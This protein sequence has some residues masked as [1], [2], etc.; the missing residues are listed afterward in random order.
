[1][2]L[3]VVLCLFERWHTLNFQKKKT[4]WRQIF[5][6]HR[7][8]E[9]WMITYYYPIDSF[10]Q[11][12]AKIKTN[13]DCERNIRTTKRRSLDSFSI[14][15]F[16]LSLLQYIW[17]KRIHKFGGN[18]KWPK[19]YCVYRS[20]VESFTIICIRYT[21]HLLGDILFLFFI[22]CTYNNGGKRE[23]S[24]CITQLILLNNIPSRIAVVGCSDIQLHS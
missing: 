21:I 5:W 18:E 2:N 4:V 22:L 7:K 1:M 16:W 19:Y 23:R 12:K 10:K 6:H 13:T 9:N 8:N 24:R 15:Q 20:R 11:Q 17:R 14:V 3:V